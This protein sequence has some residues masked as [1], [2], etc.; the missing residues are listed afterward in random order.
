[1]DRL[2]F[3]GGQ[4]SGSGVGHFRVSIHVGRRG[5]GGKRL[6]PLEA[7]VDTGSTYTWVPRDVLQRLGVTAEEQW[8]FELA[9]GREVR[10]PVAWAEVRIGARVQPTIVVFGETGS[11]PILGA[12]TLEGFGLVADTV[13]RRLLSF[14]GMGKN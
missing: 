9:N 8:P 11:Q 4:T 5:E 2:P 6:V 14:T 13:N 1:M 12:F 10:Y 7:L 3:P